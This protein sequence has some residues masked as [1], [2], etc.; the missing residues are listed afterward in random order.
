MGKRN[1]TTDKKP[2]QASDTEILERII[3]NRHEQLKFLHE[4]EKRGVKPI[5]IQTGMEWELR[6]PP[7]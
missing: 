2:R 6:L 4:C 1:A 5:L 3:K 7:G